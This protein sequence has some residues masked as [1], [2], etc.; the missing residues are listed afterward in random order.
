MIFI[1]VYVTSSLVFFTV[2]INIIGLAVAEIKN[3]IILLLILLAFPF[4]GIR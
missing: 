1:F 2:I 4:S 3:V